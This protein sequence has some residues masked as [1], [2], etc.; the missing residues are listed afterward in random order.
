MSLKVGHQLSAELASS[1]SRRR[2]S[3]SRW[4]LYLRSSSATRVGG[5][6]GLRSLRIRPPLVRLRFA[7]DV[8]LRGIAFIT[9]VR[10]SPSP[11]SDLIHKSLPAS[12]SLRPRTSRGRGR[13]SFQ[14]TR[15]VVAR[16]A[17]ALPHGR[18]LHGLS[19]VCLSFFLEEP[20]ERSGKN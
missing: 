16:R 13:G 10:A 9:S 5:G 12:P 8:G 2:R 1:S 11:G 20:L 4:R 17:N 14:A 18:A 15:S 6:I 19:P 3:R 7:P